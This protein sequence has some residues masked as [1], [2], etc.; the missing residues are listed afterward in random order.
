VGSSDVRIG[1]VH[2]WLIMPGG[3]ERVLE[4]ILERAPNA[5]IRTLLYDRHLMAGSPISRHPIQESFLGRIPGARR[6]HRQLLPLM[7]LAVEQF[8]LDSEDVIISNA[9]AVSHGVLTRPDQLHVAYFNRTMTYAWGTYHRD[10]RTFGVDRGISGVVA[11][12]AYHYVRSW[13]YLAAQRPDILVCN[14][15]YSQRRI[16]KQYRREAVV[17]YPPVTVPAVPTERRDRDG[18]VFVGRLV[19]VKRIDL[20]VRAFNRVGRGLTIIGDGPIRA[21]LEAASRPNIEFA[22]WQPPTEVAAKVARARALLFASEEDFGLA[23][24][25]A[26]MLGVPVIALGRGGAAETVVPGV[27]GILYDSATVDGVVGAVEEFEALESSFDAETI[28]RHAGQFTKAR[29]QQEIF[30]LIQREWESR[31][32][33][34]RV[35]TTINQ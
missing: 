16:R 27:T 35:E 13:D 11:R 22:G 34:G 23:P 3:S 17:I 15:H 10:L 30:D 18:Y 9:C 26:Q 19:P 28:K 25:E 6:R 20:L 12:T 32:Q 33:P 2:D 29:F 5:T 7:P 24:V 31:S 21:E 1:I 8:D 14:S 4:A